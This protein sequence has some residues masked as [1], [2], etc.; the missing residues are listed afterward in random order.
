MGESKK[1]KT[2][3]LISMCKEEL[4]DLEFVKP[5]EDILKNKKIFFFTKHYKKI[6]EKDFEIADKIIICGTSLKDNQFL[7]DIS[8][9]SW[10]KN[11][12]K[13]V[14]GICAGMQ[15]ISIL[16]GSK[17]KKKTQI[18]LVKENFKKPFLGIR[19]INEVYHLHNNEVTFPE[20]FLE[21]VSFKNICAIK[22][23]TKNIYGVLFHP[24]V[25]NRELI[26]EFLK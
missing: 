3:F 13:P 9:F 14:L 17:V 4:H 11:F 26:E 16:F 6:S 20:N 23:K 25:R 7:D 10:L 24:E 21:F 12:E 15:I 22:H 2:I 19:G 1:M 8:Y 5:V 18:G